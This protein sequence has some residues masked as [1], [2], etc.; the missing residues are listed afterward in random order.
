MKHNWRNALI[1]PQT[2]LQEAIRVIDAAALQIALVSDD[3][4]DYP[5]WSLTAI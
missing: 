3:L 4:G 1:N 5:A 2:S